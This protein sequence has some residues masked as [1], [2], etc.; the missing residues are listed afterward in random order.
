MTIMFDQRIPDLT[1]IMILK[2]DK[3]T[4]LKLKTK[5]TMINVLLFCLITTIRQSIV[6][7]QTSVLKK[8][9]TSITLDENEKKGKKF[10]FFNQLEKKRWKNKP[11]QSFNHKVIFF[12]AIWVVDLRS[13]KF[14]Q[15]SITK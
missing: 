8:I 15:L 2:L 14:L 5:L 13:K 7:H 1:K 10:T 4:K 9:H 6:N 11:E 3:K 12:N